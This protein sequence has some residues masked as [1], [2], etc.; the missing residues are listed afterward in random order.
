MTITLELRQLEAVAHE[1]PPGYIQAVMAAGDLEGDK[2]TL[3]RAVYEELIARF[4][5]RLSECCSGGA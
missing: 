1:R 2:I 4:S 3:E 5:G